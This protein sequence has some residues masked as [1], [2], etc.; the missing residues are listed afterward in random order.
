[1]ALLL[2]LASAARAALV[3][4]IGQNFAGSTLLIDS[5][6]LPADS[7]GVVGPDH[8]VEFINGRFSVYDKA[9]GTRVQTFTDL[10]FW[11]AAGVSFSPDVFTAD[12]R[13]VYD[14]TVQRW[15]AS[16]MDLT[17]ATGASN[18]L[19]LAVSAGASPTGGWTGMAFVGD[20]VGGSFADFPTLGV[21]ANGVYLG[22]N[23]LDSAFN[24]L[25]VTLV[26]FPKAD[27]L[28]SVPTIEH[29]TSF[30]ILDPGTYGA[31]LQPVVSFD[32]PA[33]GAKVL[34][35]GS[36][37][38]DGQPHSNLVSLAVLN[39]AG[40]GAATL[41]TPYSLAVDAY[42]WPVNAPQ[43]D[44]STNLAADDARMTATV[45]QIGY[46]LYGVH[47]VQ[48]NGRDAIR[49][50][51]INATNMALLQSGTI[52]DPDLYLIYP[53]IAA[54]ASGTVV[55]GC[56]GCS[57]NTFISCY[58]TVG[59]TVNGVTTFGPLVLL[60]AGV[61]SYHYLDE[62]GVNRWGDYS[63]TTVDPSDPSRFWTIQLYPSASDAWSTQITELRIREV[64]LAANRAGDSLVLSWPSAAAG[65]QLQSTPSLSAAAWTLVTQSPST[66]NGQISVQVP[67]AG[68]AGFF[69]L[70]KL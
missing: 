53:S 23:L 63:A 44:G 61:A 29:R 25:G 18:R 7:N 50:Y 22:A 37:G 52:T 17:A 11:S 33:G 64:K 10:E 56:N 5:V 47:A 26:S 58:A 20:P 3:I 16:A 68:T 6:S 38:E 40:P 57:S 48:V 15:F 35:V 49:W 41:T 13:M 34:A 24:S 66:N 14:P 55:I 4:E 32:P 69:R 12:G 60:K 39:A 70:L 46:V 1:M 27:L 51:K 21:D 45:C 30:G 36:L 54:N 62:M 42:T 19:L 59:E 28:A 31:V 65:F 67:L 9:T 8:F 43:P 2:G